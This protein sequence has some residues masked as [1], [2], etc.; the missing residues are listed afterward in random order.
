MSK[1]FG[2]RAEQQVAHA[3]AHQVGHEAVV[4]QAIEH[5][6]G[7]GVDVLAGD[8]VLGP[9]QDAGH[10]QASVPSESGGGMVNGAAS[11]AGL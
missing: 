7:I 1:S 8:G 3:A 6:Q 5:L 10:G 11:R 4:L 2:L 9:R